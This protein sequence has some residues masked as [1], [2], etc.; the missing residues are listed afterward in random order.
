MR[1]GWMRLLMWIA[2]VQ[3]GACELIADFD[4]GKIPTPGLP[5]ANFQVR[6]AGSDDDAGDLDASSK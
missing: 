1:T 4:R 5:D 2:I 6:D 3:L